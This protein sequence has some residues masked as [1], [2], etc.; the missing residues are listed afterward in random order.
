MT[1]SSSPEKTVEDLALTSFVAALEEELGAA[2]ETYR[3]AE[4]YPQVVDRLD[5]RRYVARTSRAIRAYEASC[6]RWGVS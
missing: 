6:R 3:Q 4:G 2:L 5:R 1:D